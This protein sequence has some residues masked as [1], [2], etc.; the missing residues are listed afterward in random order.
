MAVYNRMKA[1]DRAREIE[2]RK[3]EIVAIDNHT[4]PRDINDDMR[5]GANR[6]F[7]DV[8]QKAAWVRALCE[9]EVAYLEGVP[10]RIEAGE[11]PG[12]E[13]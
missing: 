8:P 10:S 4:W 3:A 5:W 6:T 2:D 9:S 7:Y 13:I 12:W 1:A 11:L